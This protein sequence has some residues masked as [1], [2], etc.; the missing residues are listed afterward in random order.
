[1]PKPAFSAVA[2]A[3]ERL[4]TSLEAFEELEIGEAAYTRSYSDTSEQG[5]ALLIKGSSPLLQN[6]IASRIVTPQ[7]C[8]ECDGTDDRLAINRA[9]TAVR[10]R[11]YGSVKL[12]SDL[13]LD[14]SLFLDYG[15]HIDL[16]GYSLTWADA[17]TSRPMINIPYQV[18]DV[19]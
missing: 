5:N 17:S 13:V 3:L 7:M 14:N 9:L 16:N 8:G 11:G 19:R 6:S 12:E 1:M 10:N 15:D 4:P 18:G 2:T